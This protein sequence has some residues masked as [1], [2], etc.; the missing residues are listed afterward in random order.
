MIYNFMIK[1]IITSFRYGY[2]DPFGEVREFTYQSGNECD[3]D[4]KQPLKQESRS[5]GTPRGQKRGY[6]D[7][8]ARRY[9]TKDGRRGKLIVNKNNRRRG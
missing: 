8:N 6:Y 3:P 1:F 4:T 2:V 9:V 5:S 7:Y